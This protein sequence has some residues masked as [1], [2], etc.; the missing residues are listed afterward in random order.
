MSEP[1]NGFRPCETCDSAGFVRVGA[2][3]DG[4][5][6]VPCKT[7]GGC[8]QIY[9]AAVAPAEVSPD[10]AKPPWMTVP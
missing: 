6:Y 1:G 8:G 10:A 2:I 7:C 4:C 5:V 3:R 9:L